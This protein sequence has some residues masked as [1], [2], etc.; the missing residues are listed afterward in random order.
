[1]SNSTAQKVKQESVC[2][3]RLGVAQTD[4][5]KISKAKSYAPLDVH[6]S[7]SIGK[8]ICTIPEIGDSVDGYNAKYG[9]SPDPEQFA[10]GTH[11]PLYDSAAAAAAYQHWLGRQAEK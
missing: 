6:S 7:Y 11:N 9:I 2:A 10:G 5:C 3:T 4:S 1:M 8:S